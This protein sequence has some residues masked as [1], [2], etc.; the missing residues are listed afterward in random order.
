MFR[1]LGVQDNTS[2]SVTGHEVTIKALFL[3]DHPLS[4]H[5]TPSFWKFQKKDQLQKYFSLTKKYITSQS[6]FFA[7]THLLSYNYVGLTSLTDSNNNIT[8]ILYQFDWHEALFPLHCY[9][10]NALVWDDLSAVLTWLWSLDQLVVH[11]KTSPQ[12]SISATWLN[13]LSF[14]GV[15]RCH[16]DF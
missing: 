1:N 12:C 16:I 15:W 5:Y 14:G 4:H 8:I 7:N 2:F 13:A 11:H 10:N 3:T 9:P 6:V